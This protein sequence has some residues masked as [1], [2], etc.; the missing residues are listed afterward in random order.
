[1]RV[2]IFPNLYCFPLV[3]SL[4]AAGPGDLAY[5][6]EIQQWR[7]TYE[8]KLKQ[9]NGWLSLAGLFWLK[10]GENTFGTGSG[11]RIVLP[12]G[13]APE[14]AGA[15]I[16][17]GGQTKL[18]VDPGAPA[19]LNGQ[20]VRSETAL[21]PDSSGD[22]D[23]ITL[24]RLSMIVIKRGE[25]YAIRLWDAQN[26]ARLGFHGSRW[27]PVNESY[28][29]TAQYTSY[30]QPRMINIANIL[31]DTVPTPSPGFVT[32]KLNGTPCRLEPVLEGDHLFFI[33]KDATS[34][35]QTYPAGR[36]LYTPLPT[37]STLVLD[38]NKAEN[39]PCAFTPYATCPLPPKQNHLPVADEAGE[40]NTN[41]VKN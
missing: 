7:A 8:A 25:R 31:G 34:G 29:V 38:F 39:P 3:I 20:A 1:M 17:H 28:R 30:P 41:H 24:G 32:F 21:K 10:E 5:R 35:R 6:D 13:A 22:P 19:L 16:F 40:L 4:A 14:M 2:C 37:G 11:N 33:L 23:R 18:R 27:F 26:P 9:D 15:F 36:F 12:E